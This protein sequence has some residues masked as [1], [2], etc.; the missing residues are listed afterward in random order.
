MLKW[1]KGG[2]FAV[3]QLQAPLSLQALHITQIMNEFD[4]D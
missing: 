1:K 2:A 4:F 3:K